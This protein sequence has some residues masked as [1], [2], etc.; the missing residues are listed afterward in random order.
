M[1]SRKERT[2]SIRNT[3]SLAWFETVVLPNLPRGVTGY[4]GWMEITRSPNTTLD[5]IKLFPNLPWS[6]GIVSFDLI[7]SIDFIKENPDF[8][9]L[10]WS[11][12]THN[13]H[14]SLKDIDDN[15]HFPWDYETMSYRVDLT[16]EFVKKHSDKNWNY[17]KL[18]EQGDL[19]EDIN[20][21]AQNYCVYAATHNPR[22]TLEFI[23]RHLDLYVEAEWYLNYI[24]G[25]RMVT[26]EFIEKHIG[27]FKT[28]N[29]G[30]NPNVTL[31]FIQKHKIN[32]TDEMI[33]SFSEFNPSVSPE[34]VK[35]NPHVLWSWSKL[36]ARENFCPR[37]NPEFPWDWRGYTM[38]PKFKF[39]NVPEEHLD[40]LNWYTISNMHK[41]TIEQLNKYTR[42]IEW[43]HFTRNPH[44]T[45][46]FVS[47]HPEFPWVYE[48]LPDNDNCTLEILNRYKHR[49]NL[50]QQYRVFTKSLAVDKEAFIERE[51]RRHLAAYRIQQ[52]WNLAR[53]DPNYALCRKKLERDFDEYASY[54]S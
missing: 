45:M 31:E 13:E 51:Y 41:L 26:L 5:L 48:N 8:P 43:L 21:N 9:F 19:W 4:Y 28:A 53:T 36:S 49:D 24:A 6:A 11:I 12:L 10:D 37:E 15:P 22:I 3:W 2:L 34:L 7:K 35:N 47:E 50:M 30:K 44:V 38:N 16:F 1:T 40:K 18:S 52:R 46:K 20:K 42:Y 23:E 32:L 25:M 33:C 29:I 27:I 54:A 39:E 17:M 14:I